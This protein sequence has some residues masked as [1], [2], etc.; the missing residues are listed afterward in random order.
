MHRSHQ[1]QRH[2]LAPLRWHFAI[3]TEMLAPTRTAAEADTTLEANS[4][5]TNAF[6]KNSIKNHQHSG[7]VGSRIH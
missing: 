2:Y 5:R 3:E 4:T 6:R 7:V 1:Q